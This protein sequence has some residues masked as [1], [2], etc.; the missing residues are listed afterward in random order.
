MSRVVVVTGAGRGIGRAIAL[1]VAGA[2]F[3]VAVWDLDEANATEVAGEIAKSGG[4]ALGTRC[5]VGDRESVAR[6]AAK[7]RE[8]LGAA[9]GLVNNAGVDR[10]SLFKDSNP[11]DWE[12]ILRVNFFGML[13]CT[14]TL[15]DDMIAAGAGRIVCIS[16]DAGRVGSSGEAVYS[17]SKAAVLGF[18]KALAREVAR[19]GVTVNAVCP[20]PT[21]TELLDA[22]R[23]GPKGDRIVEGMIK[24]V[25]LGRVA[26][27]EDIAGTIVF[28]LSEDAGYITG[29]TLSVSGGLTMA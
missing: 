27:P 24:A 25:P 2:G 26:Q 18:M 5:D 29:Q 7:T 8:R 21:D 1:R 15:L 11:D 23:R 9:W 22:V 28:F 19:H 13:N 14:K 4:R 12:L 10:M 20:G 3:A 17:G 16:S 6:A